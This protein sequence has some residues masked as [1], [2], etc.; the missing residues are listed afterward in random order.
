MPIAERLRRWPPELLLLLWPLAALAWRSTLPVEVF[1]LSEDDFSRMLDAWS[2]AHGSLLPTD[3]WPPGPAWCAGLLILVGVPFT[4]APMLVNLAAVTLSMWLASDLARRLGV[5]APLRLAAIASVAILPWPA[6][7]GLSGLAEPLAALSVV[8]LAHATFRLDDPASPGARWQVTFGA[9]FATLCRYECWA[10]GALAAVMLLVRRKDNGVRTWVQAL[11][12]LVFPLVWVG[13]ETWWNGGFLDFATSVRSNLLTSQWRPTGATL[14]TRPF[15]DLIDAAGPLLPIGVL[16]A[17]ASR[18]DRALRPILTVWVGSAVAYLSASLL[19]FAGLHNTP[20]LWL[21]HVLLLPIG[22]A[23]AFARSRLR[24]GY[25]WALVL[26]LATVT[27]PAWE[28]QPEGY[29]PETAWIAQAARSAM[30]SD[31]TSTIVVEAI[32][33][34]CVAVKALIGDPA[35][36][37]WDRDPNEVQE[38]GD[39]PPTSFSHPSMLAWPPDRIRQLLDDQHATFVITAREASAARLGRIG[40]ERARFGRYTLWETK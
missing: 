22:V 25:A 32:P 12:P 36:V 3:V 37:L 19:G 2:V 34:E 33:W 23:L 28:P 30:A 17:W 20:R 1:S 39:A 13:L 18:R 31:P 27:A 26:G 35:R 6:W 9:I 10:L 40:T 7:L 16:G 21:G 4:I 29:A 5:E 14:Y 24:P 11:L 38:A 15:V 8:L